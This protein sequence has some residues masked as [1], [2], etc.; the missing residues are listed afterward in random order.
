MYGNPNEIIREF[1]ND[2][3]QSNVIHGGEMS[4]SYVGTELIDFLKTNPANGMMMANK[5]IMVD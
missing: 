3:G 1:S 2:L 4:T 5:D